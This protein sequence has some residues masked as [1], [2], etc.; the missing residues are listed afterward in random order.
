MSVNHLG[1]VFPRW[2]SFER[3]ADTL[4]EVSTSMLKQS[5]NNTKIA[6]MTNDENAGGQHNIIADD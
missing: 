1:C 6:S 5:R 3:M 2:Q 4:A